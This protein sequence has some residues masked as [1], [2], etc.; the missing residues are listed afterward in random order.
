MPDINP[1]VFVALACDEICYKT[2]DRLSPIKP[3]SVSNEQGNATLDQ[4]VVPT[5]YSS[6]IMS[7]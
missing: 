2:N 7:V 3:F 5:D 4:T 6:V 1:D